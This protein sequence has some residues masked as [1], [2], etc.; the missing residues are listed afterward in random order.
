MLSFVTLS[1]G[2][3]SMPHE[4]TGPHTHPTALAAPDGTGH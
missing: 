1:Q 2:A 3:P 4:G